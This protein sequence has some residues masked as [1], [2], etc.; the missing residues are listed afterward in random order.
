MNSTTNALTGG[1]FYYQPPTPEPDI[2]IDSAI[3]RQA[4]DVIQEAGKVDPTI[5]QSAIILAAAFLILIMV[6]VLYRIMATMTKIF[7][8]HKAVMDDA[9]RRYNRLQ[10]RLEK[11]EEYNDSLL[12]RARTAEQRA[13]DAQLL[14]DRDT[15][16]AMDQLRAENAQKTK[17][18]QE[19]QLVIASYQ[20]KGISNDTS[21]Q[22]SIPGAG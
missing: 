11:S 20:L 18:I 21:D 16:T 15:I 9:E 14:I 1:F 22:K 13:A 6:F 7:A 5:S 19:Q 12:L 3:I 4:L 8:S 17:L 2:T 10:E